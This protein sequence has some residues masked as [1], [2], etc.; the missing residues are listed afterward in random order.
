MSASFLFLPTLQ[1]VVLPWVLYSNAIAARNREAQGNAAV[2]E[3]D[4]W[5]YQH[6]EMRQ[7]QCTQ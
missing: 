3:R 7:V 1:H 2:Y 5:R 4:L 6:V